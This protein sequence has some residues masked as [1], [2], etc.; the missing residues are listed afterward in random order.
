MRL[1]DGDRYMRFQ[2][3]DQH[4]LVI[5]VEMLNQHKGHAGVGWHIIEKMPE[6]D[7]AACRRAFKRAPG[8]RVIVSTYARLG[9]AERLQI[10]K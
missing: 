7:E 1:D 10:A 9:N 8:E 2:E 5:G 3:L 4:A 6:R